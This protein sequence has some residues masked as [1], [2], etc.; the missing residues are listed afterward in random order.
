VNNFI[1]F[2][3]LV[4]FFIASKAEVLGLANHEVNPSAVAQTTEWL[5]SS[6][7]PTSYFS[8]R[9]NAQVATEVQALTAAK[10]IASVGANQEDVWVDVQKQVSACAPNGS[11][12]CACACIVSAR[13]RLVFYFRC[14]VNAFACKP[15]TVLLRRC[16]ASCHSCSRSCFLS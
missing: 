6:G 8:Q 15:L 2:A 5:F 10:K 14:L 11:I 4:E 12:A 13:R 1:R 3:W 16:T 9:S 7:L